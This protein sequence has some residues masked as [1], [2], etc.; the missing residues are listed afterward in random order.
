M[1]EIDNEQFGQFLLQLRREK[2]LTQRELAERLDVSDK[3]NHIPSSG[4][5]N[6]KNYTARQIC[7][8]VVTEDSGSPQCRPPESSVLSGGEIKRM[9]LRRCQNTE[10]LLYWASVAIISEKRSGVLPS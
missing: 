8:A 1:H 6:I 9:L 10:A 7:R 3:V 4:G 2:A 5:R